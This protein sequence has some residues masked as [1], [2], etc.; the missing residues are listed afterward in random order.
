MRRYLDFARFLRRFRVSDQT[1]LIGVAVLIGVVVGCGTY[2]FELM[3]KG[4]ELFFFHTLP[5]WLGEGRH[6]WVLAPFAGGALLAP[7]ILAF[8]KEAT[9]DG[10]PATMVAVALRNGFMK[11]S[12][13]V[14]RMVMSAITLGSGGSAGSE[15]P[16]IQIGSALASGIGQTLRVS[17]NRLRIIAACGAAAGLASIFNAPIAG[18]L[19]AL[20]V[21]LGEFNVSSFS[22]IV[23]ASVVATAFSRAFLH[24]ESLLHLPFHESFRAAEIPL[25]A[26]LGMAAGI[27]SVVFTKTMHGMERFFHHRVG[28]PRALKPALGGLVVG[29]IGLGC[30]E[31]YGYS[32][33]PILQAINGEMLLGALALLVAVKVVAT[34]FTLGSGG[35]GG[36]LC[37]SLFIGATLGSFLGM[38]FQHFFP[39]LVLSPGAYGVVGMGALLGAVVQAPMMAI[40]MVFE[41]TNEY[42]VIL[43]MMAACIIATVVH[44][45]LAHGSIYTL[46]LARKGIDINAGREMGILSSL[47]VRDILEP[48]AVTLPATA[49]YD[50][51]LQKLLKGSG[52]YVYVVDE[53]GSLEGVISFTDLKEFVFEEGLNGLVLAR[54]LANKDL[55]YVTPDE[56]LASSLNKFSFIDMEQLPVVEV[57]GARR[58]RG[59]LTRSRLLK[60]YH[61]E[62]QKRMLM[63]PAD[64]PEERTIRQSTEKQPWSLTK[65]GFKSSSVISG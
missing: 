2:V 41:L 22:P 35:S 12:Q 10:V 30:P 54:D 26:L 58:L 56:T 63:H 39:E 24:E 64:Q 3:L 23:I 33:E 25:Y 40:I 31:V 16:I 36:I 7:F 6:V 11:W 13:A 15:G 45:G 61:Q 8:P 14:L 19:F 48:E 34:A 52:N 59:V 44:K 42:T 28:G 50:A 20:E 17:G 1:F 5:A 62:M 57:N 47:T 46:G 4:A 55:V 27:V 18:V 51:V 53:Q 37:P 29:L 21:V 65:T 43:P 38:V 32:Y 60:A 9:E 49:S